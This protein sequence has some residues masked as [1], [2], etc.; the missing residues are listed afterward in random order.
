MNSTI[1][2]LF[3]TLII[4]QGILFSIFVPPNEVPDEGAH[5]ARVYDI[6]QGNIVPSQ[7][8]MLSGDFLNLL[9]KYHIGFG[10]A[11]A[12][13]TNDY[14]E[15]LISHDTKETYTQ[16]G[17]HSAAHY[18]AVNYIPQ[19]LG[20]LIGTALNLNARLIFLL[21]RL[22]GL[23]FYILVVYTILIKSRFFQHSLLVLFA[24]PM[25]IF[26]AASYSADGVLLSLSFLY[27]HLVVASSDSQ[28][29]LTVKEKF[30]F[31]GLGILLA[32]TK[33]ISLVLILLLVAIPTSR[34]ES[35]KN[36][37]IFIGM[38]IFIAFSCAITWLFITSSDFSTPDESVMPRLQLL[39]LLSNP[40][41]MIKIFSS[42]LVALHEFYFKGFIGYFGW[43]TTPMPDF[44]YVLFTIGLIIAIFRDTQDT[45][46]FTIQQILV[47][48]GV[49]S[50]YIAATILSMYILWT[51]YMSNIAQGV[52]GRYFIPVF[53]LVLYVLAS[54][55]FFRIPA[56]I[57]KILTTM[58]VIIASIVLILGF[59]TIY[60][61]FFV[62][63]GEFYYTPTL[64]GGCG[65]PQQ[66]QT[67]N[68]DS[69]VGRLDR[70][71]TQTFIAECNDL[72]TVSFL[73]VP[74]AG[75]RTGYLDVLLV[76]ETDGTVIF[77]KK[78]FVPKVVGRN[79][80]TFHFS[81]L[82]D[83]KG[84]KYSIQIS[85]EE[86]P[87]NAATLGAI[88][89]SDTYPQGELIGADFSGDLIFS[90][91]CAFGFRHDLKNL[92]GR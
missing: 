64:V 92:I 86:H 26:L 6:V 45:K 77:N 10:K 28:A 82:P 19:T 2:T 53:P 39:Y 75:E 17:T 60:L 36:K 41:V 72:H 25:A 37:S 8:V 59:Q 58:V 13:D 27:I 69:I 81:P 3:F 51:P 73:L 91:R 88:T 30:L 40:A 46:A 16:A 66:L 7:S 89:I 4:A 48:A 1:R 38:Q 55:S 90:Y 32:L 47:F 62:L 9:G 12:I 24:M 31:T 35:I 21:G 57:Q 83:S 74:S 42:T 33:Q 71:V 29:K 23:A 85:P 67:E 11:R 79:W 43:F 20:V 52:Q 65:L 18:S 5:F 22:F 54:P 80:K 34:F 50:L 15:D 44:V 76:D 63:C 56:M 68:P 78:A 14:L 49:F 61:K 70:P 87:I 84:R